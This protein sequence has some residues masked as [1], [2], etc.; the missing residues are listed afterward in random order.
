MVTPLIMLGLLLLPYVLL[1][2]IPALRIKASL[3]GCLGLTLVFGFT[4]VGHFL[5]PEPMAEMIPPV[6]PYRLEMIYVSGV[7]EILAGLALLPPATRAAA[8]WF[9]I[10]LLVALL[11][12]NVYAA[13]ERVPWGPPPGPV[14]FYPCPP[15]GCCCGVAPLF[16]AP[17]GGPFFFSVFLSPHLPPPPGSWVLGGRKR[18]GVLWALLLLPLLVVVFSPPL[19]SSL[20]VFPPPLLWLPQKHHHPAVEQVLLPFFGASPPS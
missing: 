7:I 2:P 18:Y 20:G 10:A 5:T 4:G 6:V 16:W 13:V 12:L 1:Q 9:V 17:G 3:R 8:G 15:P 14:S 11:P 19:L